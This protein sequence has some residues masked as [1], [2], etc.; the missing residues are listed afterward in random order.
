[1]SLS[2][3][4][5]KSVAKV[6]TTRGAKLQ[7]LI[8]STMKTA[9]DLVGSTLGPGGMSVVIERQESGLPPYATKDGVSVYRAMAFTDPT[10]QVLMETAREASV[11][12][13]AEAGDGTTSTAILSEALVRK[14]SELTTAEPKLSPQLITRKLQKSFSSI[15]EPALRAMKLDCNFADTR[16]RLWNV[17]RISANG[18][19]PLADAVLKCFDIV[20]DEGNV[21]ISESSGPSDY[22][23]EKINGYPISVGYEDCCGPFFPEFINDAATQQC[24]FKKP[25]WILNHGTLNDYNEIFQPAMMVAD[26]ASQG[27]ASPYIVVVATG[28]SESFRAQCAASMKRE[29]AIRI[30]PLLA[31][32]TIQ[33]S[34]QLDFLEDMAALT[35]AKLFNPATDSLAG[36]KSLSEFGGY[37]GPTSFEIGR[38][39]GS[40]IGFADPMLLEERV[41]AIDSQLSG[42]AISELDCQLLKERKA[43]LTSGIA[44]LIVRGSSNG[45]VKERRDRAEDAICAVRSAIKYGALRGGGLTW[46]R[47]GDVLLKAKT[48]DLTKLIMKTVAVPSVVAVVERLFSN[49]GF[50]HE[51]TREIILK[52]ADIDTVY[53]LTA[54]EWLPVGDE[55]LLDSFS[56]IRDALRNAISVAGLLGTCG[57]AVVFPRDSILERHEAIEASDYNKAANYDPSER[58]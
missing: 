28:F 55:T 12:T 52:M 4:K 46:L 8:E 51:E 37:S 31:P 13:A 10:Q 24:I 23:I 33:Q 47:L 45:E 14:I 26:A 44:R 36:F 19:A 30:F 41:S 6:M 15:M 35:G 34:S 58:G 40:V 57:G 49:A 29:G 27:D 5:V 39:R 54:N 16:D 53:D 22:Q 43:K 11:R 18:D 50:T 38:F 17:A 21:T 3:Q 20:G 9:S 32:R 25:M 42:S 2:H 7:S 56:A 48:D 1:M